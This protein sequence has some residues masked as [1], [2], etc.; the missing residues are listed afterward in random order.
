[1][2]RS[3]SLRRSYR[4]LIARSNSLD[5]TWW[6]ITEPEKILQEIDR[7]AT[8]G[9]HPM[10]RSLSLKRSYRR[11]LD[12][13]TSA[14]HHPMRR[15]LSQSTRMTDYTSVDCQELI[16]VSSLLVTLDEATLHVTH[17]VEDDLF[18]DEKSPTTRQVCSIF[19]LDVLF[20]S[21]GQCQAGGSYD[22][23]RIL[24]KCHFL[25]ST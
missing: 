6:E 11:I 21:N 3:L 17:T 7:L 24:E 19:W 8:A 10:R 12:Q 14:G 9:H 15:S 23:V 4:R 16:D 13:T 20:A 5:I 25:Q 18:V 1:M 2:R 22:Q